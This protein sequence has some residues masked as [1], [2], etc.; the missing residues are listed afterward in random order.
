MSGKTLFMLLGS[1]LLVPSLGLSQEGEEDPGN[2]IGDLFKRVKEIK[3]PDSVANLPE[4]LVEL[5]EAYLET[6]QTVED[7]Q[8]E[9]EELRQAVYELSKQNEELR[10]AVGVKVEQD[11][12]TALMKPSEV[13]ATSLVERY[14]EDRDAADERYRDKY[15]KVVGAV[16]KVEAGTQSI[17]VYLRAD[18]Q[19]SLVRC[20]I[21]T[22]ADL[23]V[24]VLPSQG[25]IISRNDRRT[26]LTVGQ[27][28][29]VVGTCRGAS[30][31]VEMANC[32]I[33]GLVEKRI[34]PGETKKK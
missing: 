4:Q 29:A 26:L 18:G 7:L 12:L 34:D 1:V 31:N 15:L 9:V 25:R 21:Q 27:P 2:S 17:A 5:K 24:D 30:L 33:D 22:G 11:S 19:D 6:A 3:V 20:E 14:S 16:A 23:F 8:I 28:V 32:R 13:S 10:K